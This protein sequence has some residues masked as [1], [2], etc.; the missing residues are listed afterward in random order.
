MVAFSGIEFT[1]IFGIFYFIQKHTRVQFLPLYI[2]SFCFCFL[3]FTFE[4]FGIIEWS[5][6][7]DIDNPFILWMRKQKSGKV[8]DRGRLESRNL[9]TIS[10]LGFII[11]VTL[12]VLPECAQLNKIRS[13]VPGSLK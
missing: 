10:Y 11:H 3:P 8:G 1:R 12:P 2:L 13:M 4:M 5:R 9:L 6:W 7:R